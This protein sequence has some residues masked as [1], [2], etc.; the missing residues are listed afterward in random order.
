MVNF[1]KTTNRASVALFMLSLF[2]VALPAVFILFSPNAPT[3]TA[4]VGTENQALF[5]LVVTASIC[6]IVVTG[7]IVLARFINVYY[8]IKIKRELYSAEVYERLRQEMQLQERL[9][10]HRQAAPPPARLTEIDPTQTE[11]VPF[12]PLKRPVARPHELA[13]VPAPPGS[14]R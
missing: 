3:I 14:V 4:S 5:L 10:L 6:L 2:L 1:T 7:S 9:F 8:G 12:R 13:P 11:I